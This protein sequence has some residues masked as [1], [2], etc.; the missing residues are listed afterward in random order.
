MKVILREDV[1]NL[2]IIGDLVEV[3]PGYARNFLIPRNLAFPAT[4]GNV[5]EIEHK[6]KAIAKKREEAIA[7]ARTVAEKVSLATVTIEVAVG[8]NGKLFG[9]VT[10]IDIADALE[11]Q[12][13]K[14][15][16]RDIHHSPIKDLGE[17]DATVKLGAGVSTGLKI[18]VVSNAP[19]TETETFEHKAGE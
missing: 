17:H 2:G 12:G 8:E 6:K 3:K 19:A 13:I 11:K 7:A 14:V 18:I 10:S 9:S 4:V 15:D 1:A 5:A 16:R